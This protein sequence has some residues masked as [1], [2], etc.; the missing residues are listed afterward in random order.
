MPGPPK[1][2]NFPGFLAFQ[3]F[4]GFKVIKTISQRLPDPTQLHPLWPQH[5]AF[6]A[7]RLRCIN[8]WNWRLYIPNAFRIQLIET[9]AP[10][11]DLPTRLTRP[12]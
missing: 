5:Q 11:A 9:T 6:Y 1:S 8:C 12:I 7:A 3:V 2:M 10:W 4:Q